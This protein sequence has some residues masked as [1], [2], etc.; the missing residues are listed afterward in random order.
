[1]ADQSEK[2]KPSRFRSNQQPDVS[3]STSPV[4]ARVSLVT[5]G[6]ENLAK[7]TEFYVALGWPQVLPADDGV[8]FFRMAG[9][10]LSIYPAADLAA[11][12]MVAV[13]RTATVFRTRHTLAINVASRA[14]VD[15]A[16]SFAAEIG[17]RVVK[18]G[19]EAVWG[20]YSGYFA[21]P[22]GN[23][24]EVAHNPFWPLDERGLP[25]IPEPPAA[26]AD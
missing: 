13:E 4:P 26:S 25:T 8:S 7:L 18:V 10:I 24:W 1:M 6:C 9:S 5:L 3:G 22:E 11:D 17:G 21:D 16:L 14:E 15:A 2:S 23:L 20:G 12:A 19:Q